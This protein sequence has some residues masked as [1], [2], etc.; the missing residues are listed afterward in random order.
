MSGPARMP[1]IAA[2][3]ITDAQKAAVAAIV[4]G[5][6]GALRGVF[7][8]LL[9]SPEL[10]DRVQ[11][12]GEFLRWGTVLARR[13]REL[14][15]L[16]MARQWTQQNEWASHVPLA[17]EAGLAKQT[18]D[19]LAKG[20]RPPAMPADEAAAWE[21]CDELLREHRVSDGTYE[22]ALYHFGERGL[23]ELLCVA[24]YLGMVSMVMNTVRTPLPPDVQVVPLQLAD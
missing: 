10:M 22:N 7:V 12:V 15:I 11:R 21:L 13:E 17:I 4:A 16:Y 9:R 1:P 24:G 20:R 14:V 18:V 23:V 8:A 19:A 2:E 6:R 3:A 5:P